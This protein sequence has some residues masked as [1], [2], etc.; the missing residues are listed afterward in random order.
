[1]HLSMNDTVPRLR[2]DLNVTSPPPG[3]GA[4]VIHVGPKGT[5]D[6]VALRGFELSIAMMLDGKRTAQDVLLNC[7]RLG[8]AIELGALEGFVGQLQ[9]YGLLS[10]RRE[11]AEVVPRGRTQWDASVRALFRS[12]LHDARTGDTFTARAELE[13]LLEISPLTL[14]AQKL[15]TWLDRHPAEAGIEPLVKETQQEWTQHERPASAVREKL[16]STPWPFIA[17]LAG[18]TLIVCALLVPIPRAVM[19]GTELLPGDAVKL[20]AHRPGLVG[21]V[22]VRDG[23]HVEAGAALLH[24]NI[25][26]VNARLA[27]EHDRLASARDALREKLGHTPEGEQLWARLMKADAALAKARTELAE[28]QK[29]AGSHDAEELVAH[30]DQRFQDAQSNAD[31]AAAALDALNPAD[32][33]EAL[34]L[35]GITLDIKQLEQEVAER[36]VIAPTS[37]VVSH[38]SVRAGDSV[39]PDRALLQVDDLERLKAVATVTPREAALIHVGDIITLRFGQLPYTTKVESIGDDTVTA[40]IS[41]PAHVLKTGNAQAILELKPKSLLE[42]I[43]SK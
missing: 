39:E 2:K 9:R 30:A 35:S 31:A 19:V 37:G 34:E 1:M 43:R 3:T 27:Q 7:E 22:L 24:W 13:Q 8:L 28:A 33:A 32:S 4:E 10:R 40:E 12:A 14:E 38:V 25:D 36:D 17:A 18:V 29:N 21:E 15:K 42:R 16:T 26:D 41:N 11:G 5:D 23:D 6:R 20:T